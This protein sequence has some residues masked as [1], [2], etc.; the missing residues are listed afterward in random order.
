[1][2][3]ILKYLTYIRKDTMHLLL[4]PINEIISHLKE[5]V[6]QLLRGSFR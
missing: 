2:R 4:T 1:M 6:L 3:D 5:A